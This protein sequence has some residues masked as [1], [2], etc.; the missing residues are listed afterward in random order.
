MRASL[1]ALVSWFVL[2]DAGRAAA[3]DVPIRSAFA[4]TRGGVKLHYLESGRASSDPA[5]VL[6]PGWR[7]PASLWEGQL[8]ALAGRTRVIALDPRSQGESSK[9]PD[10]NTPETR[11]R[12]LHD[13]LAGLKIT[14][15]VLVGWSQGVQD[16]AAYLLE[17]GTESLAGVVFVDGPPSFGAEELDVHKEAAARILANLT[18]YVEHPEEFSRGMVGS[19][20]KRPHPELDLDQLAKATLKTP[21]STGVAMLVS[22]IFGAD[23]RRGLAKLD[24]PALFIASDSSPFLEAQKQVAASVPGAKLVVL[25]GT[26]HAVFIDDRQGFDAALGELLDRLRR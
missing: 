20:F 7:L 3:A 13:L 4:T 23:R 5:L 10:G 16:V 8:R 26:G 1:L 6:I 21:T 25:E 2:A 18:V 17:F 9:L 19:L 15:C 14:R 24:R 11:A 22:D 12:D